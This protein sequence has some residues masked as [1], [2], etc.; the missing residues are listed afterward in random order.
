[1]RFLLRWGMGFVMA[2]GVTSVEAANRFEVA[3]ADLPIGT[4]G[5]KVAVSMDSD[6]TILGFSIHLQF[7]DNDINV[8]RVELGDDVDGLN[9]EWAEGTIDNSAGRARHRRCRR[10]DVP[11]P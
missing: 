11:P 6:Q 4:T 2:L 7:D 1:M 8:D 3:D 10:P 9:P 5:E